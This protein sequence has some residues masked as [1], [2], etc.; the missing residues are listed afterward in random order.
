[1][2]RLGLFVII[3][4]LASFSFKEETVKIY[5]GYAT[6]Q[7]ADT[8]TLYISGI[9]SYT[10]K[11]KF[12]SLSKWA[13]QEFTKKVTGFTGK[14]SQIVPAQHLGRDNFE[15]IKAYRYNQ[16]LSKRRLGK[17]TIVT[18]QFPSVKE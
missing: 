11:V 10:D 8:K 1:M 14:G 9:F 15:R 2:K 3:V 16:I 7:S 5:Y 17:Q 12:S 4:S 18:V 6:V 13:D